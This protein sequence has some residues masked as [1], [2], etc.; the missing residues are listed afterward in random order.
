M[1]E[2]FRNPE[3]GEKIVTVPLFCGKSF[4][5]LSINVYDKKLR[6]KEEGWK[7]S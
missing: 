4:T 6:N 3:T 7:H 1:N 2:L 5:R